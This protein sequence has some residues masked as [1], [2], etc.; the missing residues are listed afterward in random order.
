MAIAPTG[1]IYKALLF[2]GQSSRNYGV[3][4]TGQAVYNAPERDVEMITIPGRNGAFALDNGRFQNIEVTYPAGIFADTEADF[5]EAVSDFRNFLC[6]KKGYVRL[7]DEYN[8]NEYRMAVYKSGLEVT[9]AQLKAGEFEITFD[10]KPQ[11]YLTSG[12]TKTAVASGG[13]VTNPTLFEASPLL[14]VQGNG[15]ISF[16]GYQIELDEVPYGEIVICNEDTY[17]SSANP[18]TETITLDTTR[19]NT[20][21]A[22]YPEV[23]VCDVMSLLASGN[24]N[25]YFSDMSVTSTTNALDASIGWYSNSRK[26]QAK[27][28]LYPDLG[29]GFIYGTSKTITASAT[30]SYK[31]NNT[32]SSETIQLT[33][34]YGGADT[35]TMTVSRTGT[36]PSGASRAGNWLTAPTMYADSSV[37][38]V[39]LPIYMD[40]DL[41]EVYTIENSEYIPLNQYVDLGS[42]LPKLAPGNNTI[43]YD[44]TI[45]SFEIT[46]RYWKV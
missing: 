1:A 13:T 27:M 33:I 21:D 43:A 14:E 4:I 32:T 42:D 11:R 16:N 12:E 5:A 34:A 6:S 2:D 31:V 15:T 7:S 20:G 18:Y 29:T 38:I 17:L 30:Y 8:P 39:G 23:N 3:Y 45:T 19:V 40:C 37:A 41:G 36:L 22:I 28:L 46:P 24:A 44:N 25:R 9:P 10:C 35:Y 26:F